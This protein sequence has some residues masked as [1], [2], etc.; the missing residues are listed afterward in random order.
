[1]APDWTVLDLPHVEQAA[2]DAAQWVAKRNRKNAIALLAEY[3]DLHQEARIILATKLHERAREIPE[4]QLY[5]ELSMDLMNVVGTRKRRVRDT[6]VSDI[7]LWV[8][9][10]E[11]SRHQRAARGTVEFSQDG[12][13]MGRQGA[14]GIVRMVPAR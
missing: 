1:M 5:H 13:G 4:G 3:D 6:V 10:G 11:V 8:G 9:K 2:V 14:P 12:A 7:D